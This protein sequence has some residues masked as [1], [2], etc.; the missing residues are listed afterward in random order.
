MCLPQALRVN[1]GKLGVVTSVKFRIVREQPVIRTA[2]LNISSSEFL[3]TLREAQDMFNDNG[4]LPRWMNESQVFWIPQLS[5]ASDPLYTVS[6]FC[7][8]MSEQL[9]AERHLFLSDNAQC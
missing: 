1:V 9:K 2:T 5:E 8:N 3:Q 6:S 7:R 4:E